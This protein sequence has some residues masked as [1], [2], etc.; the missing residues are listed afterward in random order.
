ML[1]QEGQGVWLWTE[2][3]VDNCLCVCSSVRLSVYF[4]CFVCLSF[5]LF[6]CVFICSS[7]CMFVCSTVYM[8]VCLSVRLF[9]F[10]SVCMLIFLYVY[11]FVCLFAYLFVCLS[12]C[13]FVCSSVWSIFYQFFFLFSSFFFLLSF[14]LLSFLYLSTLA[15]Y[16]SSF[17]K[18]NVSILVS[19]FFNISFKSALNHSS[20]SAANGQWFFIEWNRKFAHGLKNQ[21]MGL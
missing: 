2:L 1:L 8:I 15:F 18:T 5:C 6:V 9:I 12:F 17:L 19:P 3:L 4:V 13:L 11:L 14:F 16:K 20:L 10:L 21:G 7:V